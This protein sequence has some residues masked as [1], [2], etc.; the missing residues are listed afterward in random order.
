LN[1]KNPTNVNFFNINDENDAEN[2][3]F[4]LPLMEPHL[5]LD[6]QDL[7][8]SPF[9]VNNSYKKDSKVSES[10]YSSR[11]WTSDNYTNYQEPDMTRVDGVLNVS[12][13]VYRFHGLSS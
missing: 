11:R 13:D 9:S 4:I 5:G 7:E 1:Q 10:V 12:W 3:E 2:N 6:F 8:K